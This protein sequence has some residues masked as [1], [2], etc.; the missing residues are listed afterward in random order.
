MPGTDIATPK[1]VKALYEDYA[2]RMYAEGQQPVETTGGPSYPY[3][4]LS[5]AADIPRLETAELD[6]QMPYA[7]MK[8]IYD[9]HGVIQLRPITED[10]R[11]LLLGCG[12][13]FVSGGEEKHSHPGTTTINPEL[14]ANPTIVGAFAVN[15]GLIDLLPQGHYDTL[16]MEAVTIAGKASSFDPAFLTPMQEGFKVVELGEEKPFKSIYESNLFLEDDV[17][18]IPCAQ[19]RTEEGKLTHVRSEADQKVDE[20]ITGELGKW[21]GRISAE[22]EQAA[23]S[24]R[25]PS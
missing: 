15:R 12:E 21:E 22:R 5:I 9:E 2:R 25:L 17:S 3:L 8:R 14:S 11:T 20:A 19:Q 6:I 16:A 10:Q 23:T 18:P 13:G 4:N 1:E 7:E 24:C